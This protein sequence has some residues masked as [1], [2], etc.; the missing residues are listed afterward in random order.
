[1][2]PAVLTTDPSWAAHGVGIIQPGGSIRRRPWID[3]AI[4]LGNHVRAALA[5]A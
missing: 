3:D 5:H 4:A 1:L 2:V